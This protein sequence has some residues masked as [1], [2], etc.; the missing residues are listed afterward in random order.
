MTI[1][2]ATIQ[3]LALITPLFD[4]YRM[5]YKQTSDLTQARQFIEERLRLGES[6]IYL[7]IAKDTP[8]QAIGFTQLYPIFSSVSMQRMYLL[9]DLYVIKAYRGKGAGKALIDVVKERCRLE[10][11]KGIVLQTETTNPA[12]KIYE[13]LGFTKDPDLHYFWPTH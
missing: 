2:Q 13:Y 7:A 3:D 10:N 9:N 5:F 12:Q 4:A 11:Q 1:R 8:Q 6:I